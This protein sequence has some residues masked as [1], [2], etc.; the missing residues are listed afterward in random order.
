MAIAKMENR[1]LRPSDETVKKLEKELDI[2]LFQE[3]EEVHLHTSKT[4]GGRL[5]LGDILRM[6]EE[7]HE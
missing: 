1:D 7:E 4:T 2:S 5:T 6:K 3:V